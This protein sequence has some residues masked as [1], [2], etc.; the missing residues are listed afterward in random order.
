MPHAELHSLLQ[1]PHIWRGNRTAT[2]PPPQQQAISSGFAALDAALPDGGWPQGAITEILHIHHGLGELSLVIPAIAAL[3]R[4]GAHAAW[5][6]PPF[7][8]YAP[9]L[10]NRGLSL[11]H[12]LLITPDN[13]ADSLWAL[14]QTLRNGACA[15][16]L[17]WVSSPSTTQLRRLQLAAESGATSAFLFRPRTAVRQAS[18]AALRI[19]FSQEQQHYRLDIIKCRGRFFREPLFIPIPA[20]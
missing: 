17:G 12:N 8:P 16:V 14:E 5:I 6:A 13:E 11:T 9:A 18:P 1:H 2:A 20:R 4:H 3:N 15:A 7:L 19:A 10:H